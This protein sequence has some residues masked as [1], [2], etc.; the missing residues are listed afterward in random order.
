MKDLLTVI[1]SEKNFD[2]TIPK[3]PENIALIYKIQND[4]LMRFK[5]FANFDGMV[6]GIDDTDFSIDKNLKK[7]LSDII[8]EHKKYNFNGIFLSFHGENHSEFVYLLDELCFK[9]HIKLYVPLSYAKV[10]QNAILVISTAISG[11][12]LQQ[13]FEYSIL[14]YGLPRVSAEI[15]L[16]AYEFDIPSENSIPRKITQPL[17]IE[18]QSIFF[19]EALCCNYFTHRK[20]DNSCTFT[21]FDDEKSFIN[22]MQIMTKLS[23]NDIFINYEFIEKFP[24]LQ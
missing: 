12:N 4:C 15:S 2:K 7:I 16:S 18:N 3:K 21:I 23:V 5:T 24:F 10:V 1:L 14:Q 6:L 22:K 19:S 20:N 8:F 11:G 17:N 13:L 9:E